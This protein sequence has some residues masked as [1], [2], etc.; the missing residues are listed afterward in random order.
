MRTYPDTVGNGLC[1]DYGL[2]ICGIYSSQENVNIQFFWL[3][4]F[5]V[6]W[7]LD[8]DHTSFS[9]CAAHQLV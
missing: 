5:V 7:R 4:I 8:V 9:F 1:D 3:A 6:V 2:D